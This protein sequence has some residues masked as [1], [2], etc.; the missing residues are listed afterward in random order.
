MP[1]TTLFFKIGTRTG[2]FYR[3]KALI[4]KNKEANFV[5]ESYLLS[6]IQVIK[7]E[8]TTTSILI[9]GATLH[10]S[11]RKIAKC[12]K[13]EIVAKTRAELKIKIG[14]EFDFPNSQ[15]CRGRKDIKE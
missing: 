2:D 4:Y 6:G 3:C 10:S 9:H 8:I 5:V 11:P 1:Y 15:T 14:V 12:V 13:K 7:Y